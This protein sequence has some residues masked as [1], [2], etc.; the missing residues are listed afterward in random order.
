MKRLIT[1]C[2]IL[3]FASS[4]YAA[5]TDLELV[6]LCDVSGSVDDADFA[7]IRD[8]YEAAFRDA[9]VISAIEAGANGSIAATLVYW[10]DTPVQVVGWTLISDAASAYAFADAIDA[11]TRPSFGNTEMAVAMNYGVGLLTADNGYEGTRMVI[12]V[13]GDGADTTAGYTNPNPANVQ[14]A[15]DSASAAGIGINALFVDD[16]DY[17]GDDPADIIQAIPYGEN[18]VIT[19]PGAFVTLVQDFDEF[20][21]AVLEKIGREIEPIPAPGAILLGSIGVGFVG[22][23]RRRRTL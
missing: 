14:A 8:G 22:W 21:P 2:L 4:A 23:L 19:G 11:A 12:D 5:P 9:G 15:R 6:L 7:L 1:I 17:F 16:R 20:P 10:S 18:N 3:V 13:T